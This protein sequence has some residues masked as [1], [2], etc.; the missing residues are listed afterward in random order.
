MGSKKNDIKKAKT[1]KVSIELLHSKNMENYF[2]A[3]P[4]EKNMVIKTIQ[5]CNI[6]VNRPSVTY[7]PS[8]IIH[9]EAKKSVIEEVINKK[10]AKPLDD[11][12][13]KKKP[14]KMEKYFR[15]LDIAKA[16]ENKEQPVVP[17]V[18]VVKEPVVE[19]EAEVEEAVNS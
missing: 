10:Y 16:N 12:K 7:L 19:A 1:K 17:P 6:N 5:D 11:K 9:D 18:E 3:H 2:K 13:R 14:N 8:Y 15:D 4:E